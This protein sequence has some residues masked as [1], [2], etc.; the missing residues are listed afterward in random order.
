VDFCSN[1]LL[2]PCK[3]VHKGTFTYYMYL[4]REYI[5]MGEVSQGNYY[6]SCFKTVAEISPE[7]PRNRQ[8][9]DVTGFEPFPLPPKVSGSSPTRFGTNPCVEKDRKARG[10]F[11]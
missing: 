6:G 10:V 8:N 2:A 7:R 5:E 9:S 3:S 1:D 11:V 4:C